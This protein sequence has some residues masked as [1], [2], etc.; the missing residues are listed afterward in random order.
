MK[1]KA[2]LFIVLAAIEIGFSACANPEPKKETK[3]L[4][5]VHKEDEVHQHVYQCAMDC[6]KGKKY[7]LPGKC[8]ICQKDLIEKTTEHKSGDGHIH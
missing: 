2:L 4:V 6:E 3:Q 5:H 7:N 8:P 1:T